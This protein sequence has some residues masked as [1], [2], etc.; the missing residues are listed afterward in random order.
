[1]NHSLKI[2][3]NIVYLIPITKVFGSLERMKSIKDYGGIVEIYCPW[4]GRDS[5]FEFGWPCGAVYFQRNYKVKMEL[6]V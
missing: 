3:D 4:S 6:V 1:M 2:A 5:G